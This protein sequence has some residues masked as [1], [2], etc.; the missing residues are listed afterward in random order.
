MTETLVET[1]MYAKL[2][3]EVD[4]SIKDLGKK[5]GLYQII[6]TVSFELKR[7][8]K[9]LL[10]MGIIDTALIILFYF[11]NQLQDNNPEESRDYFTSYLG[12]ISFLMMIIGI[13]FASSIIVEDFEKQ[14]GNLLFPKIERGRLLIGRY[15][16]RY[17]YAAISVLIYYGEIMIL[18]YNE[19]NELPEMMWNSFFWALMYL[20]LVMA[21]VTLM[22]ALL[23]RIG[24][25]IIM[26]ITFLL[27]VFV[28]ITTL[29]MYS[30][31]TVEPLF[32]ITYYADIITNIFDMPDPNYID[33]SPQIGTRQ[34]PAGQQIP[35]F[36]DRVFRRWLTP[37]EDSALMGISIYSTVFLI[38]AYLIY[39]VKQAK[40]N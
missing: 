29:L 20:H 26:S 1:Q 4:A 36:S 18:T 40:S 37:T 23:N 13:L 2:K 21:F 14:T 9:K 10:I 8:L 33:F 7:N 6:R 16:A 30:E 31:S 24:T 32:D 3:T 34:G 22:S 15:V 28:S 11:I 19:Y 35:E 12:M 39:R 27:M 5:R 25:A 17:I 38:G